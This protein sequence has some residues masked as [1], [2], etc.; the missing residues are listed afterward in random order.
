MPDNYD[1]WFD[2][3]HPM[4]ES[5]KRRPTIDELE[6]LL[7]SDADVALTILPNGQIVRS[8]EGIDA[9]EMKPLTFR[10]NLGGEYANA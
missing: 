2:I 5:P 3:N 10:E 1:S 6:A 4:N 8:A 7:N 9:G